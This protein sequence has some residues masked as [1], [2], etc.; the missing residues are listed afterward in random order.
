[1]TFAFY[2]I[3]GAALAGLGIIFARNRPVL[4]NS[5]VAALWI[6]TNENLKV[7]SA[8]YICVML[9]AAFGGAVK[10]YRPPNALIVICGV[11]IFSCRAIAIA[12]KGTGEIAL[13]QREVA[14]G[15][16]HSMIWAMLLCMTLK[17]ARDV[18]AFLSVYGGLRI[19]ESGA[20]GLFAYYFPDT[21]VPLRSAHRELG[22]NDFADVQLLLVEQSR[23]I[24]FTVINSVDVAFHLSMAA[25]FMMGRLIHRV[26]IPA[27]VAVG[28]AGVA[29]I[30][31]W[32]RTGLAGLLATA[33]C[34]L[35]VQNISTAKK[36]LVLS[37]VGAGIAVVVV[38]LIAQ[39]LATD[40]R[41]SDMGSIYLRL[42]MMSRWLAHIPDAGF[43][44]LGIADY[45]SRGNLINLD[46]SSE[47]IIIQAIMQIGLLGAGALLVLIG[48]SIVRTL[49]LARRIYFVR[50]RESETWAAT[51]CVLIA[52][53]VGFLLANTFFLSYREPVLWVLAAASAVLVST[54]IRSRTVAGPAWAA[55]VRPER[56]PLAQS[57]Q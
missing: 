29:I 8:V 23:L 50:R 7:T 20:M 24:G 16:I 43:F 13:I 14:S 41:L 30:H 33:V 49:H 48:G 35:V 57:R 11:V 1:M 15:C 9:L 47:N 38:D 36:I 4:L 34:F 44:G 45:T 17:N 52:L 53:S 2:A 51:T 42:E 40:T 46:I 32:A 19:I 3:V 26:S 54:G 22:D 37:I 27:M 21:F 10:R 31:T 39:R 25:A 55:V 18:L 5:V 56:L 28:V 6:F 12:Y